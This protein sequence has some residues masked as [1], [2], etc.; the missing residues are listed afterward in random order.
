MSIFN[1]ISSK[2]NLTGVLKVNKSFAAVTMKIPA[3]KSEFSNI[4]ERINCNMKAK[5]ICGE[6]VFCRFVNHDGEFSDLVF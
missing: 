5:K 2:E 3:V 1:L 4:I 6:L